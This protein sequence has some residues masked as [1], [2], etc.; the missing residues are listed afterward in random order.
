MQGIPS[1][2]RIHLVACQKIGKLTGNGEGRK[3]GA[4]DG[5]KGGLCEGNHESRRQTDKPLPPAK[6]YKARVPKINKQ[7]P[8]KK[9]IRTRVETRAGV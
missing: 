4:G 3:E 2:P 9:I 7:Q 6:Y 1:H 8:K 5:E